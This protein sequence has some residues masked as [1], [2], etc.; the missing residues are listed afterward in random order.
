MAGSGGGDPGRPIIPVIGPGIGLAIGPLALKAL[1]K[2]VNP[3]PQ[4]MPELGQSSRSE[5]KDDESQND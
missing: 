2:G 3:L 4:G 5:K 1:F